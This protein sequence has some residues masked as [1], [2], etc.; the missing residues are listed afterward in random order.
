M[1]PVAS[2]LCCPACWL[3]CL[4]LLALHGWPGAGAQEFQLLQ[5][6]GAVSVSAGE[7]LTLTC[8]VTG[9]AP[10]GPVRWFKDSGSGRRLV[11]ADAG[12]FPRV[13]RA[14]SGSDTDFTIHI[15][16]TRS[17]DAGV[18]HC[19][20]FKKGL[21][22]DEEFRSGSGTAVSVSARPS[23]PSVS[24]PPSRAE[25]G[26]PV[27]F[28]CT[29]GGFSPRD[30]TV[31]WLKN[32]AKLPDPQTQVLPAHQSVSYNVSSTVGVSLTRADARSQ[33]TCQIEHSTL[34]APLRATYTLSDVLRVP[35]RLQVGTA[36]A[37][38]VALNTSVT[39]TCHAEG[40]YPKDASL[41]WLENGN[42]TNLG[43]SSALSEN[44]DGTYTLQSSLEVKATEQRSQSM[45]TCR[46][47][48]DSQPPINASAMLRLS[49]PPAEPGKDPTS[50]AADSYLSEEKKIYIAVAVVCAVLVVLVI[51]VIYL[52]RVRQRKGKS[53]PSVRLHEPEKSPGPAPQDSDPNNLTYADL[54]F[55]KQKKR[56]PRFVEMS[57]Q[58][59]YACIQPAATE[60]NL[61]YADLDMVHL[62][63]SPKRPAP[64][65][66]EAISE[67]ASVQIQRK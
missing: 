44:A 19:V 3:P 14:V 53:S 52:I 57:P 42:E 10:A 9:L 22:A 49:Q 28:T 24:G 37:V 8:S 16:D 48:H 54:N 63:K 40:F 30:I 55:D 61:T 66:E 39:F 20:K 21:G 12:S 64:R 59:E 45:F 25:P 51:A 31:T 60:D 6:Q 35:P 23:A 34:P 26:P 41:T 1:E 17:E 2:R 58:S 32:G 5:P 46:V 36:P 18:Y 38:P 43:K 15:N 33:L 4:L 65:P 62:S 7:T 27:T 56:T 47:V 29:S 13:T 67:Y 11:Y 50:S